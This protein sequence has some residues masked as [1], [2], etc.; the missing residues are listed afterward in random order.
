MYFFKLRFQL[1]STCFQI[2]GRINFHNGENFFKR[3]FE[4]VFIVPE[5][6]EITHFSIY[7]EMKRFGEEDRASFSII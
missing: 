5:K 4:I 6:Y 1:Y 2:N 3:I 7:E